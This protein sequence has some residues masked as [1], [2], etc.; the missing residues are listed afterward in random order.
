M[1]KEDFSL[2]LDNLLPCAI[3][4]IKFYIKELSKPT[5]SKLIINELPNAGRIIQFFGDKEPI[6]NISGAIESYK[7]LDFERDLFLNKDIKYLDC[8]QYLNAPI[9]IQDITPVESVNNIGLTYFTIVALQSKI[10]TEL[11]QDYANENIRK[12]AIK[13]ELGAIQKM[14][15]FY[16]ATKNL[17][18]TA[19]AQIA[20]ISQTMKA[21]VNE[22]QNIQSSI[23]LFKSQID[24]LVI[25]AGTLVRAPFDLA[26][27]LIEVTTSFSNTAEL[28]EEQLKSISGAIE[29]LSPSSVPNTSQYLRESAQLDNII[30]SF[31]ATNL[32]SNYIGILV[33]SQLNYDYNVNK[34]IKTLK[35]FINNIDNIDDF[36]L[37]NAVN[38]LIYTGIDFLKKRLLELQKPKQIIINY[39]TSLSLLCNMIYGTLDNEELLR[40]WNF[41]ILENT[42]YIKAGTAII[43]YEE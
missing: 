22:V 43:Y 21:I 5:G 34:E 38:N 2:Y 41:S 10:T 8:F 13:A 28:F 20:T 32:I 29:R 33:N 35:T 42:N 30:K 39:N 24:S 18:S 7:Y 25:N 15:N 27:T 36:E 17:I 26:N 6:F 12:A 9:I 4:N 1:A 14:V 23:E 37:K 40:L 31:I 16:R 19:T 3:S 11:E